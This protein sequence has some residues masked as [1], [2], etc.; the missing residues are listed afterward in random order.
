MDYYRLNRLKLA[1][2]FWISYPPPTAGSS[3]SSKDKEKEKEKDEDK[4][5]ITKEQRQLEHD[6]AL[7]EHQRS[8]REQW[9]IRQLDNDLIQQRQSERERERE[10]KELAAEQRLHS[11]DEHDETNLQFL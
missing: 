3:S 7:K 1:H 2:Q 9:E 10:L 6:A 4:K 11:A 5:P 8:Q